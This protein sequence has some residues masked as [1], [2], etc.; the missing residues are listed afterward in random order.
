MRT[1]WYDYV[2]RA[3]MVALLLG[4][5]VT[6]SYHIGPAASGNIAVFPIVLSSLIL[7]LH[8][9]VGGPATAAVL[10]NAVIGLGGFA[11]AM[12]VLH[13][14]ADPL[15]AVLSLVLTLAVSVGINLVIF[16]ARRQGKLA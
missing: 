15:G 16:A 5:V 8:P 14:T 6:L 7:I 11:V 2:L 4:I 10:A 1:Y 12:L 3:A 9:R 13:L